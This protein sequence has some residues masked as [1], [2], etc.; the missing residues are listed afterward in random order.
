MNE[1]TPAEIREALADER[2]D[3]S[4]ETARTAAEAYPLGFTPCQ[5]GNRIHMAHKLD[6][7]G[8]CEHCGHHV[9]LLP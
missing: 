2:R 8:T 5:S 9:D 3:H 1:P 7:A 6:A 4:L